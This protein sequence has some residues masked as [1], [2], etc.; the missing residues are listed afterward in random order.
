[1][2]SSYTRAIKNGLNSLSIPMRKV[3]IEY[4]K[5]NNLDIPN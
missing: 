3:I 2:H 5:S 1:M 4:A